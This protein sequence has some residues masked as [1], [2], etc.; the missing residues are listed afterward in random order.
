MEA[1]NAGGIYL[2]PLQAFTVDETHCSQ[3]CSV[4]K[5]LLYYWGEPLCNSCI[6]L[7]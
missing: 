7:T 2:T 4:I 6:N 3:K 1:R 5:I